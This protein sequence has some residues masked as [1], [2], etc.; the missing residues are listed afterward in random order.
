[1]NKFHYYRKKITKISLYL[2]IVL[3]LIIS[4]P[5]TLAGSTYTN[6]SSAAPSTGVVDKIT[7]H[8]YICSK[9][10]IENL[11]TEDGLDPT[12]YLTSDYDYIDNCKYYY[13]AGVLDLSSYEIN[14]GDPVD[15]DSYIFLQAYYDYDGTTGYSTINNV[16]LGIHYNENALDVIMDPEVEAPY[17]YIKKSTTEA[18]SWFP[19]IRTGKGTPRE[20]YVYTETFTISGIAIKNPGFITS[21]FESSSRYLNSHQPLIMYGFKV[22]SDATAGST[23]NFTVGTQSPDSDESDFSYTELNSAGNASA[24]DG[25]ARVYVSANTVSA[26]VSGGTTSSDNTLGSLVVQTP[27]NIYSPDSTTPFTAGSKTN[28][29]YLY[30]V[31]NSAGS[32]NLTAVANDT[33]ATAVTGKDSSNSILVDDD[34]SVRTLHSINNSLSVGMNSFTISVTAANGDIENYTINVYRLSNDASITSL[35]TDGITLTKSS[36]GL[37]YTGTTNFDDTS[38][39]INVTATHQ[40]A[41]VAPGNGTT[42][43][44]GNWTFT[45]SGDTPNVRVVTVQAENCNSKYSSISGNSCTS[46][47]YTIRISRTAASNVATLSDLKV[48]GTSISGFNPSIK[49]YN[50]GDVANSKSSVTIAATLTD[51]KGTI[52]S[53]TGTCTLEVGD[54]ACKVKTKAQDNETTDE[55]TINFHRLSNEIKL[56]TMTITSSPQGTLTPTFTSDNTSI[57]YTYTYDASASSVTIAAS[58]KDTGKAKIAMANATS[59]IPSPSSASFVANNTSQSFNLPATSKVA[60]FVQAEDGT[61]NTYQITLTRQKSTNN[62]LSSFGITYEQGGTQN[63]TVTPAFAAST[64][65]YTATV[66]ADITEVDITATKAVE[67]S[68]ITKIGD[69][70]GT[71]ISTGKKSNLQFGTNT[72]EITV[73]NEAGNDNTYTITLTREKYSV[74]TLDALNLGDGF[75]R[76]YDK[77]DSNRTYDHANTLAYTTTQ[78]LLTGTK[79][80]EYSS[81]SAIL[82]DE[83]NGTHVITLDDG[84]NNTFSSTVDI[85]TGTNQIILTVTAQDNTQQEYKIN[86]ER[87]KNNDNSVTSLSV[88]DQVTPPVLDSS[89]E[90]NS[91][92]NVTVAYN[93]TSVQAA[94]VAIGVPVGAT[95]SKGSAVTGLSTTEAKDF[96]F[97]ITA[98]D[99]TSKTYTLKIT[100]AP[101]SEAKI[102]KVVLSISGSTP[103]ATAQC[104]FEGDSKECTINVPTDTTAFIDTVTRSD[105]AT[106]IPNDSQTY[107][108]PSTESEKTITYVVTSQDSSTNNTYTVTVSRSKSSVTTLSNLQVDEQQVSNWNP[109]DNLYQVTKDG[110]VTLVQIKATV[111]EI[112]KEQVIRATVKGPNDSAARDLTITGTK[113]TGIYT[114]DADLDF[115][116]NLVVI[117]VE[118]ENEQTQNYNLT[119]T[120]QKRNDATL[121]NLEFKVGDGEWTP[122]PGF[123]PATGSYTLPSV[124]YTDTTIQVRATSNDEL[125]TSSVTS[126]TNEKEVVTQTDIPDSNSTDAA[127]IYT[128]TVNLSTGINTI[129]LTGV[130]HNGSTTKTYTLTVS[131]AKNT[132]VAISDLRVKGVE[133][134]LDPEDT[135]NKTYIVT[136]PNSVTSLDS[137]TDITATLP[138]GASV[139]YSP[140]S[141]AELS[142]TTDNVVTMT[143]T[144]ESGAIENYTINIKRTK[145]SVTTL[146]QAIV[147]ITSPVETE[148]DTE[149]YC[150][151]TGT[152]KECSVNVPTATNGFTL[153]LVGDALNAGSTDPVV[154]K[155]YEMPGTSSTIEIPIVVTAE[156]GEATDNYKVTVNRSKS[157]NNN[158]LNISYKYAEDG[159]FTTVTGFT[160]ATTLYRLQVS[161]DQEFIWLSAIVQDTDKATILTDLSNEF[162]LGLG[163]QTQIEIEVKAE[164]GDIQKYYI[165]V[166]RLRREDPTLSMISINDVDIAEFDPDTEEYTIANPYPYATTSVNVKALLTDTDEESLAKV[167]GSSDLQSL[168][169]DNDSTDDRHIYTG[170]FN[171]STGDNTIVLNTTADNS[172]YTKQYVIH[173]NRTKNNSTALSGI[174]LNGTNA[175]YNSE[176]KVWEVTVPNAVSEAS[177]ANTIV[178]PA[179]GATSSDALAT[180]VV[181]ATNLKTTEPT[182]VIITVTAEDGTVE[183]VTLRVTRGKSNIS[184]LHTLTVEGG[185]FNPSFVPDSKTPNR[186]RITIPETY[187]SVTIGATPTDVNADVT[188]IG[189]FNFSGNTTFA[190]NVTSEDSS[191]TTTYQLDIVR[192]TSSVNTLKSITVSSG[193]PL[194]P[195]Y[196]EYTLIATEDDSE[197]FTPD[198]TAYSVTIPGNISTINIAAQPTDPRATITN[199]A[200]VLKEHTITVGT[201]PFTIRVQS[202]AGASQSYVLSITR[203]PKPFNQLSDLTVN[204][205]S[206]PDFDPEVEEYT[207]PDVENSVA[208]IV[209]GGTLFDPDSSQSGFGTCDLK[210]GA[211]TCEVQVTAQNGDKKTYKINVTR[212]ASDE[213]R[214]SALSVQGYVLSPSFNQDTEEYSITVNATKATLRPTDVTAIAKD[215]TATITKDAELTLV[216]NEY[217][218]YKIT[219][220]SATGRAKVY[221]IRVKKPYSSDATLSGVNLT[222]ASLSGSITAGTLD[223][224]IYV[225]KGTTSFTV[226]GV[227]NVATTNVISGNATYVMSELTQGLPET[228]KPVIQITTLAEDGVTTLTY[229][230]TIEETLSNDATLSTLYVDGYPFVGTQTTFNPS[231]T[232][233]SIGNIDFTVDGVNVIA[234]ATNTSSSIRYYVN[235]SIQNNNSVEIPPSLGD[236]SISIQVTAPDGITK[237]TYTIA[238]KKVYST[239][240]RLANLETSV[241][242]LT[243]EFIKTTLD[244]TI[245][246]GEEVNSLNLSMYTEDVNAFMY[247]DGSETAVTGTLASPYVYTKTGLVTGSNL[248]T[249]VVKPQN[250]EAE[251]KT[252]NVLIKKAEPAA[253]SDATL[254][255]LSVDEHPFVSLAGYTTTTFTKD[256]T[257]YHIGKLNLKLN[258]LKVNYETT[259]STS[260]VRFLVGGSIVTPNSEGFITI[261]EVETTN[262]VITVQ[263]TAPNN[264][265]TIN[266]NIHYIKE[267]SSNAF[268]ESIVVAAGTLTPE[269]DRETYT[270]A[271]AVDDDVLSE[272]IT[273]IPEVETSLV[274]IGTQGQ[275]FTTFPAV[276]TYTG[277]TAG[278]T[279]IPI[280]VTAE[281]GNILYYYVN[282]YKAGSGELITSNNYGHI[283]EDGNLTTISPKK[284]VADIKNELDNDNSKLEIWTSDETAKL[285]DGDPV[286][287]GMIVKLIINDIENDRKKIV[288]KGDANGDGK[289][290][291]QDNTLVL[292]HYLMN[293]TLTDVYY[294]AGD[295]NDDGKIS[296]Q[297]TTTILN[298][299]L[300]NAL[301]SK[302]K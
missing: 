252:Y 53:G 269:F 30:Y 188:G 115:G 254:Q 168:V 142:T 220:T 230:F 237:K 162:A 132:N 293:S 244:Y 289:V 66:P 165:V 283:I 8:A 228:E 80:N 298:H 171:I 297:D 211:N 226:E 47:D 82:K 126:V 195:A 44:P 229:N 246:V 181:T 141:I 120:R 191:D 117:T 281:N 36:D 131:R 267:A 225:P 146:T 282:I 209:V 129:V 71:D 46:A 134:E 301:I 227:P 224:T 27:T 300:G 13:D 10:T 149:V 278:T 172:S 20:P 19:T 178:T 212:K 116:D 64:R 185:S 203:E 296:L 109:A 12:E 86:V 124:G 207:L 76:A 6:L 284:T 262:G 152:N 201:H 144:A 180:A 218:P 68:K 77:T 111:T 41:V 98:E 158:L 14:D 136:L 157:T 299:Y 214:L 250:T 91:T 164:N 84:G 63:V 151:F 163:T 34:S 216:P 275:N 294:V 213:N 232:A 114:F 106:L 16:N 176:D 103:G 243:P 4:V 187:T 247:V 194:D 140:A 35:T 67:F 60:I 248:V 72:V 184:T 33:A 175:T 274:T 239:N 62:Y 9:S 92:Y 125:G 143:V 5:A 292:N 148:N 169:V 153:N 268:I 258:N 101:N 113:P 241:G 170:T 17:T 99:G 29:T 219:V 95:L 198:K 43:G 88:A 286:G 61:I 58:V 122:V 155:V 273:V 182:D 11:L 59:G 231:I 199:A 112:G 271:D 251:G 253:N 31:P 221:T 202:E 119:I 89:D 235:G 174:K 159:T 276:Y 215:T 266:Y 260:T 288:I 2:A 57:P 25:S 104:T 210:V 249:I 302:H 107:N 121:S 167:T 150:Y 81:V 234:T 94:E 50:Y 245:N 70:T 236:G 256:I 145:S 177:S 49:E 206:V 24:T 183:P 265:T 90:T 285:E 108:M 75:T 74:K 96:T 193:D 93:K 242:V 270:Y 39:V 233:Y 154:P 160:P 291:L 186:Y 179:P 196:K 3:A 161:G 135:S 166:T 189:T 42:T 97:T 55:Y 123:I 73:Y 37:T 217:V 138:T 290:S 133:A 23:F 52:V 128:A 100:R 45:N 279:K 56:Q 287:T 83:A 38:T 22:K 263:V 277:I 137:V 197:G 272:T 130:A 18:T 1:M 192:S 257:D 79:T 238:F 87:T 40:N 69:T 190:V 102:T 261:P 139:A 48:D 127:N 85:P 78:L 223:Y 280:T 205:E 208:S 240:A 264:T 105:G 200:T 32:I 204:D 7:L 147:K 295:A 15:K 156:D 255:M 110:T 65:S 26:K 222:N 173:L 51:S 118:A 21:F 28:K 54:N 259:Q